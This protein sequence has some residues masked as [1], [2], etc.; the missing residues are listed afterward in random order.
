MNS[1]KINILEFPSNLGLKKSN[2]EIEPGVKKLPEWLKRHG[3]HKKIN[4]EKTLRIEP[5]KYTMDLDVE[6]GVRN[7][8][9]IIEYAIKQ[10]KILSDTIDK[11]IFQV[12]IGGDCSILIGNSIALK[13]KGNYGL[14]F[15]DGHTDF[16]WPE[17]SGTGGAAGMDLAIV[18]GYGHNKLTNIY[19]QKPY[20]K[21]KNVFCVGNREYD[22]EYVSPILESDIQ[23]FDLKRLRSNGF[24]KTAN[25]FLELVWQNNLDGFF[26]HLD[27][28]VLN[29]DIMPAVDSREIDGLTYKEFRELL[30]PLLS[31]KKA[32]GIE[33]TIL[34][35]NLDPKGKYVDEFIKNFIEILEN[36]KAST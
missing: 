22:P 11:N 25:Q 3:F 17:L 15:I 7:A 10:S 34:D 13:Q 32:V 12:I 26:I 28:D 6:S 8:D 23:Y 14:F 27:V 2:S 24:T 18:T 36:G 21:E 9:K 35:P 33:I 16:I 5:P 4:P 20:F 31:S 29:D 1:N 19:N 30:T